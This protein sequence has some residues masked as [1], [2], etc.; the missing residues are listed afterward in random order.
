MKIN[1]LLFLL[2]LG[3]FLTAQE[4][5]NVRTIQDLIGTWDIYRVDGKEI[6]GEFSVSPFGNSSA[7]QTR[8]VLPSMKSEVNGV[9]V[10]D[11]EIKKISVFEVTNNGAVRNYTGYFKKPGI[12]WFE[13]YSKQ[14]PEVLTEQSSL[15]WLSAEKIQVWAKDIK[16]DLEVSMLMIRRSE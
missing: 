13:G 12:L 2:G 8:F 11:V 6:I 1:I 7:L 4:G 9:W 16:T 14:K 3:Y 5:G 10:Y 15:T